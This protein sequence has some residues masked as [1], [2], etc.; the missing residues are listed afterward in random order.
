MHQKLI[1]VTGADYLEKDVKCPFCSWSGN[2]AD[3]PVAGVN[4]EEVSHYRCPDCM[5]TIVEHAGPV[6]DI[7][8]AMQSG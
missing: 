8:T 7:D 6:P 4:R 3:M 1:R 5:Q 2:V